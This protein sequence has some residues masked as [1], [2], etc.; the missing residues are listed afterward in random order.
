M[1]IV[2]EKEYAERTAKMLCDIGREEPQITC[3]ELGEILIIQMLKNEDLKIK[4]RGL[5]LYNDY[6]ADSDNPPIEI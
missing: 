1:I 5:L 4:M 3:K 6:M 2:L